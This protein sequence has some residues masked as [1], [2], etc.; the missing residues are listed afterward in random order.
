MS[1]VETILGLEKDML[2]KC[3]ISIKNFKI[4]QCSCMIVV[5]I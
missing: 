5:R 4:G 2:N 3:I 1:E